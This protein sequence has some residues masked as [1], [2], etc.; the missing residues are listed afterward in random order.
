MMVNLLL[1]SVK[2]KEKERK[3]EHGETKRR[4][5]IRE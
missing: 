1:G 2:N 4:R 3:E 5:V